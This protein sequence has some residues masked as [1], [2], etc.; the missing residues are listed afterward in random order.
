MRIADRVSCMDLSHSSDSRR[1][2]R[3]RRH[4][5]R[6]YLRALSAIAALN[7][8]PPGELLAAALDIAA[9]ALRRPSALVAELTSEGV[10]ILAAC[11]HAPEANPMLLAR[12]TEVLLQSRSARSFSWGAGRRAV[13]IRIDFCG[14]PH[15]FVCFYRSGPSNQSSGIERGFLDLLGR[16]LEQLVERSKHQ[17]PVPQ[18]APCRSAQVQQ[19]LRRA[20]AIF[21]HTREGILIT[22]P[23]GLILDANEAFTSITGYEREE[24]LGRNP[25]ILQSGRQDA[26]FYRSLWRTLQIS[27]YWEGEVWNRRKNG[28]AYA[29]ALAIRAIYNDRGEVSSYIGLFSDITSRKELEYRADHD[30]LTGL[31]NRRL[32]LDRLKQAMTIG[33]RYHLSLAVV[34][35]DLDGFKQINDLHGHACGDELLLALARRMQDAVRDSDT[36]G[37]MGGDEFVVLLQGLSSIADCVPLLGRLHDACLAPVNVGQLRIQVTASIGVAFMSPGMPLDTEQILGRA[38]RA[39]YHAKRL[40]KNRYHFFD[41]SE[42][43]SPT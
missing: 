11:G 12:C 40:G 34:Y 6:T 36:V 20:A 1:A 24:V 39:M 33:T 19:D 23:A 43:L 2:G 28:E 38:D 30:T 42:A 25:N 7:M 13:G 14:I 29:E 4:R 5:Q 9:R 8:T 32:L 16:W 18:S 22:S 26:T 3:F 21:Q 31:P 41:G 27:G 35:I 15:G 10:K 37:R 17:L